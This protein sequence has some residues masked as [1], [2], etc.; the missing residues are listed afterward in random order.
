MTLSTA[1]IPSK[2]PAGLQPL[3]QIL[4][5][6]VKGGSRPSPTVGADS[7]TRIHY[8]VAAVESGGKQMPTGHLHLYGFESHRPLPNKKERPKPLLFLFGAGNRTR[9]CTLTQWNLNPPSLPIPPCPHIKFLLGLPVAVPEIFCSLSA[10]KISTAATRS[11]R[12]IRPRRR[13]HRFPVAVPEI[14]CSLSA[15]KISTAATRS[16]RFI[17]PYNYIGAILSRVICLV[18]RKGREVVLISLVMYTKTPSI[19]TVCP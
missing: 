15:R 11:A 3:P 2:N 16:A 14:F 12:F 5:R 18:N 4:Y 9:T 10:R 6:N 13:S 1:V 19:C 7:G 17:R 8:G